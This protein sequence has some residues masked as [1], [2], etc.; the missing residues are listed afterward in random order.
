MTF[1]EPISAI[2]HLGHRDP[3]GATPA[4]L[5]GAGGLNSELAEAD[6]L[7][8]ELAGADELISDL[9]AL[10]DAG[11]VVVHEHLVGPPRYGVSSSNARR[12]N[13]RKARRPRTSRSP[14]FS[15]E[16]HPGVGVGS[17]P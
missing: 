1:R 3:A 14:T 13:I 15:D 10:V 16:S 4:K 7:V 9:A 8:S 12:A 17:P 5:A 2:D 11:L 6:G